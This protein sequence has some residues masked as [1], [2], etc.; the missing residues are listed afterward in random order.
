[1]PILR[2]FLG[3]YEHGKYDAGEK[4]GYEKEL[5][6]KYSEIAKRIESGIRIPLLSWNH[7]REVAF[8]SP[9]EQSK[10]LGHY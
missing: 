8:L 6:R 4:L 1:M 9:E 2:I 3:G 10:W 7:H 5:L